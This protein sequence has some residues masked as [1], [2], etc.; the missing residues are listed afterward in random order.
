MKVSIHF[1]SKFLVPLAFAFC[2]LPSSLGAFVMQIVVL[3]T[4]KGNIELE[5]YPKTAP[6]AV[7][8][9][10]TIVRSGEYDGVIFHRV[11][12]DLLVQ[13]GDISAVN[14]NYVN[15]IYGVPFED[16]IKQD[17]RF[18]SIGLV[19]MANSGPHSNTTQFFITLENTPW[20][21]NNH[22]IFGKVIKGIDVV[23]AISQAPVNYNDK[24]IEDVKILKAYVE[25]KNM[26]DGE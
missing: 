6:L 16:E 5:M 21:D 18:D 15:S 13:T 24:P 9:F 3:Q 10:L 25:N 1:L 19:A 17:V 11:I 20:L 2:I 26:I 7:K 8:N 22:T 23:R 12:K 14:G 4:T